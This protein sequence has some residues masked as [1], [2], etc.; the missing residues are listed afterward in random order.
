MEIWTP[1]M[2]YYIS[3]YDLNMSHRF[4]LMIFMSTFEVMGCRL[5]RFNLFI[6]EIKDDVCSMRFQAL[7]DNQ[8]FQMKQGKS[9]GF[10]SCDLPSNLKL[11]SNCRFQPVWP[12]N[13]MDDLEKQ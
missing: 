3:V 4:G 2:Q 7:T 8:T 11:G 9:E 12:C 10:D 5:F 6:C 1:R 13:F